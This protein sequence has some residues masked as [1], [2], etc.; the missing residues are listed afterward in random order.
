MFVLV[1]QFLW[2]HIDEM[3]GKD[4]GFMVLVELI[5]YMSVS[6]IPMALPIA[7][8]ISSVMVLGNLAEHHELVGLNTAGISL[9]RVLRPLIFLT[10]LI[11]MASFFCSSKIMPYANLKFRTK[12]YDI[13]HQKLTLSLEEKVF[14][15]DFNDIVIRI[16]KKDADNKT[17]RDVLIYDHSDRNRNKV[18]VIT[19]KTGKMQATANRRFLVMELYEGV[20]YQETK[21]KTNFVRTAFKKWDKVFDLSE[22]DLRSSST[23]LFKK[24]AL[25]LGINE[26]QARID[27]IDQNIKNRNQQIHQSFSIQKENLAKATNYSPSSIYPKNGFR[28][29]KTTFSSSD[30]FIDLFDSKDHERLLKKSFTLIQSTYNTLKNNCLYQEKKTKE[31]SKLVYRLHQKF[32]IAIVCIIFLFIGAPMGAIIRKGGFGYPILI[33]ILFFMLFFISDIFCRRLAENQHLSA[34]LAP[35]LPC[36]LLLPIG[37]TLTYQAMFQSSFMDFCKT[38]IKRISYALKTNSTR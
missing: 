35:W 17:I 6:L 8:L 7:V 22:F 33:A 36:L 3:L 20:Q 38:W 25:A 13:K 24:N 26:L 29:K 9:L 12:L 19:A 37:L 18:S 1:M 23:E 5:F 15:Y 27:S 34:S 11:S 28:Q 4:F 21:N 31:K 10:M 16:D 32:S 30:Q 14:N 2:L